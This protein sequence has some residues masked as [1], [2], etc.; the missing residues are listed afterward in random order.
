MVKY[1]YK[2]SLILLDFVVFKLAIDAI[3]KNREILW[4]LTK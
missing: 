4:F 1:L 3:T 2:Q